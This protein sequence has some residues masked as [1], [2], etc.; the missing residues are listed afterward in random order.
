MD[1]WVDTAGGTS[2]S[3]DIVSTTNELD[4]PRDKGKDI[5]RQH[6]VKFAKDGEGLIVSL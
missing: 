4:L 1:L 2:S 5:A 6:H 3:R